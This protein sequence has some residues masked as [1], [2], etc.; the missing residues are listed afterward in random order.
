MYFIH[1]YRLVHLCVH[2]YFQRP[3]DPQ[4]PA[5]S[6]AS[7][8]LVSVCTFILQC[9]IQ[10]LLHCTCLCSFCILICIPAWFFRR[11]ILSHVRWRLISNFHFLCTL[12]VS[13]CALYPWH[14]RIMPGK[15]HMSSVLLPHL[16]KCLNS[17]FTHCL[18]SSS[19]CILGRMMTAK[20]LHAEIREK[21]GAY[22]GGAK[23]GG[24]GLFA[25]YSYR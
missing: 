20:F 9:I 13:V 16:N 18:L 7:C 8:N 21:G 5:G 3:L 10:H 2:T 12:L 25:F 6:V 1:C 24:D 11:L 14:M 19:L 15:T 17:L 23:I 22:G 4:A